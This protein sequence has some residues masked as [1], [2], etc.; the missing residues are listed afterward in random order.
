MLLAGAGGHCK[1][2][3]GILL[4]QG[5][6]EFHYYVSSKSYSNRVSPSIANQVHYSDDEIISIFQKNSKF[7]LATGG[8]KTRSNFYAKLLSL[9]GSPFS[10]IADSSIIHCKSENLGDALNIM[11]FSF[12][13]PH[14][15]I[16]NGCLINCHASIHHDSRIGKFVEIAPGAKILGGAIIDD[17]AFIGT[18]AVVF[19]NVRI[20]SDSVVGAG[21]MVK[22]DFPANSM[23]E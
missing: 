22:R 7:T 2:L 15:S 12:I 11:D 6:E 8:T 3:I 1:E 13:G 23:M 21:C 10:V 14:T 9:G 16:G 18:N 19:P 17:Y 20:G 5:I 4:N